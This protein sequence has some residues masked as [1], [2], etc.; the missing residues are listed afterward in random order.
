MG[1]DGWGVVVLLWQYEERIKKHEWGMQ[2]GTCLQVLGPC[3]HML[4]LCGI[5]NITSMVVNIDITNLRN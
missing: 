5:N 2:Q 3:L 1:E 4:V